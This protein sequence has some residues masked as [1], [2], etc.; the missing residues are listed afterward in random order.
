MDK[1]PSFLW[2]LAVGALFVVLQ[3]LIYLLR[4]NGLNP[5]APASDYF[6]FFLG[7]ALIGL[8]LVY[9][10][11]RSETKTVYQATLIG[12]VIGIPFTMFG[13]LIGGLLGPFGVILFGISPGIF[14][15]ALGY[16]L[17]R[18]LSKKTV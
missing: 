10:L 18:T 13:M 4:F 16:F 9:F 8:S 3:I 17:A 6:F 2:A 5:D 1:K 7:G 11:G 15:T 12:F 14:T